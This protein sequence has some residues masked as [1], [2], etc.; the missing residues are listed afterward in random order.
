ME[1]RQAEPEPTRALLDRA[2]S[3]KLSS[4]K[5]KFL[6]GRY[7]QYAREEGDAALVER[8]KN[9]ARAWV[10]SATGGGGPDDD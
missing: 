7:L 1:R 5:M 8:V 3:L 9:K 10:E 4:K 2:T 6:F